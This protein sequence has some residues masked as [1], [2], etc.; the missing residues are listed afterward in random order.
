MKHSATEAGG[1]AGLLRLRCCMSFAALFIAVLAMAAVYSCR[2][3]PPVSQIKGQQQSS[4]ALV[5]PERAQS[6]DE[7]SCR[8]FV[9]DFYDWYINS[10]LSESQGVSWFDVP[11]L[12][13]RSLSP[14]LRKLLKNE[15]AEQVKYGAIIHLDADPFL[16]SQDPSQKYEVQSVVVSNGQCQAVVR[17]SS[18]VRPELSQSGAG[19]AF[20][21][22]HYSFYSEDGTKEIFPDDD[23]IHMLKQPIGEPNKPGTT[24][25]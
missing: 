5:E 6:K 3:T 1:P 12:R 21:N 15:D 24:P 23:L 20:T 19:W 9:Q 8:K 13:P 2:K 7:Q 4:V 10:H 25:R 22:F 18:E 16:N 17:G 11:L 14:E